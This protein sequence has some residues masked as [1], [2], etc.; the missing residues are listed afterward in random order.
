MAKR[1]LSLLRP[2]GKRDSTARANA[3]RNGFRLRLKTIAGGAP[4]VSGCDPE[5]TEKAESKHR[6]SQHQERLRIQQNRVSQ[7][8]QEQAGQR[9]QQEIAIPQ[10]LELPV[11]ALELLD[12]CTGPNAGHSRTLGPGHPHCKIPTSFS[13]WTVRRIRRYNS[14]LIVAKVCSRGLVSGAIQEDIYGQVKVPIMDLDPVPAF[15]V[16]PGGLRR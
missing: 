2:V 16:V 5:A 4:Q 11:S 14:R 6:E 15:S 10:R 13:N 7:Q 12:D 8:K 3:L 1:A 9:Q